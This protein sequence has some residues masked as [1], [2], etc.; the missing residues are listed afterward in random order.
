MGNACGRGWLDLQ[1]HVVRA[2]EEMGSYYDSIATA[3]KSEVRALLS[4][5]PDLPLATLNDD[6]P[7][8]NSETQAWLKTIQPEAPA[9][10]APE[11]TP[12]PAPVYE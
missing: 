5:Y 12:P 2:C 1:R 9:A 7:A 4:D 10:A 8:A 6:T 11:Y 3:V